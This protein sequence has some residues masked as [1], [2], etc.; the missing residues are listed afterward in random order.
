MSP[1]EGGGPDPVTEALGH[2]PFIPAPSPGDFTAL[3]GSLFLGSLSKAPAGHTP[4]GEGAGRTGLVPGLTWSQSRVTPG[5]GSG[6][7]SPGRGMRAQEPPP[8][9]T[10]APRGPKMPRTESQ[11]LPEGLEE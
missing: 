1:E 3:S 11:P 6:V 2:Y 10:R 4:Q 8:L 9:P 5:A 7:Q